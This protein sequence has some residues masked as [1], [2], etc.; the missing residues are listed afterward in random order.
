[1][2]ETRNSFGYSLHSREDTEREINAITKK[3]KRYI[4]KYTDIYIYTR[5]L[6]IYFFY[7]FLFQ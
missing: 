6:T 1:M 3:K 7:L 5:F 2:K 4:A